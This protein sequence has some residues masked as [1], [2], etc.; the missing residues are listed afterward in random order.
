MIK[1]DNVTFAY[2][3][4]TIF[5]NLS[6]EINST[7]FV[8]IIGQNGIGKST[9]LKLML[10]ELPPSVGT[11]T[12]TNNKRIAY[13]SQDATK[14]NRSFPATVEE[15]I[16]ASFYNCCSFFRRKTKEDEQFIDYCLDL[17]SIRQCKKMLIGNLSGGQKQRLMLAKALVTK[18]DIIVLDEPTSNI[19]SKSAS[20][21]CGILTHLNE[22]LKMVVIMVS[23][24]L[25]LLYA[26][27]NK[28]I[29]INDVS[30]VEVISGENLKS[31]RLNYPHERCSNV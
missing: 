4:T 17:V 11:I 20:S 31:L 28:I 12:L 30:K 3:D 13:I 15:L 25:P 21:I 9:F 27:A 22:N 8:G 29:K 19:D 24:D 23:H 10:N 18:P 7:D 1:F 16:S 6:L 2:K 26:H 5:S 14:F